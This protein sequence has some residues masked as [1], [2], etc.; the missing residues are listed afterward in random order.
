MTKEEV[1]KCFGYLKSL[2]LK[3]TTIFGDKDSRFYF[4]DM[5]AVQWV[6]KYEYLYKRFSVITTVNVETMYPHHIMTY[7][8]V[9]AE[10][11][12]QLEIEVKHALKLLDDARKTRAE[13]LK[14]SKAKR[15][16]SA[17]DDWRT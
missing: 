10:T 6:A 3:P 13:R 16:T 4:E 8:A 15:I 9:T 2:G 7:S 1:N 14:E 11:P 12:Y 17:A 5:D